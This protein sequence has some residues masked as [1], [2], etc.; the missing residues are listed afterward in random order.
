[1][2]LT[3][4]IVS[5]IV[6]IFAASAGGFGF[7]Q[8]MISRKDKKEEKTTQ[9]LIDESLKQFEEKMNKVIDEKVNQSITDCGAIGE[10]SITIAVDK[11]RDEVMNALKNGLKER[12]EEGRERFETNSRAIEKN[13]NTLQEVLEIQK[14]ANEKFDKLADSLTV[15]S[16]ATTANSGLAK[17]CAEGV[18]STTYDRIL[19]VA[20]RA[21]KQDKITVS[22]KTNLKQLY[23]SWTEL[24]GR[25]AKIDT[26]YEDCM[27]LHTIPDG[28]E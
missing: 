18:R 6:A 25:D 8:F 27:K 17:A 14:T 15:L 11:V 1:M 23:A 13:T 10:Q 28:E 7:A 19:I 9:D 12:G 26:L 4:A 21:L 5:I 24:Q 22:E 2:T 3:Q 20:N 16:E